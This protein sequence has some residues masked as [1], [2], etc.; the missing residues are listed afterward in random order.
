MRLELGACYLEARLNR[1]CISE[2]ICHRTRIRRGASD[3]FRY[4]M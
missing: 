3:G 1:F 4:V 2:L